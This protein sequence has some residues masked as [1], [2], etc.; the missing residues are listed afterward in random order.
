M[1]HGALLITCE[2]ASRALPP[3]MELG[4]G[5]EELGSHIGWDQGAA[6]MADAVVDTLGCA[7]VKGAYTRLLV[8]LN[9][10]VDSPMVVPAVSF[11]V[12]IP[13]NAGLSPDEHAWRI[14]TYHEPHWRRVIELVDARIDRHGGCLHLGMHSFEPLVEPGA[15]EFDVGV[16]FDPDREP[17]ATIAARL[18]SG[19]AAAGY[20]ARPNQPYLGIDEG[21]TTWLRSRLGAGAYVGIEIEV[22]RVLA[23]D[24]YE[25][26]NLA[27]ALAGHIS[28][29]AR[30]WPE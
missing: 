25:A 16:L 12:R 19:L 6:A 17:E 4:I 18:V 24:M 9:R 28:R 27:Q 23:T 30:D 21:L 29:C 7:C 14:A 11:G 2:H 13:A 26:R 3:G 1:A 5:A 15:R 8:D 22:S 20:D 10:P